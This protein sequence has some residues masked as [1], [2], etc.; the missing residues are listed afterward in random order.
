MLSLVPTSQD[1]YTAAALLKKAR[2]VAMPTETVYGL[3]ADAFEPTAIVKIFDAKERPRFDPLIVH[4]PVGPPEDVLRTLVVLDDYAPRGKEAVT[5]LTRV[6]WPGPLT[7]VLPRSNAVPDLV[8]SGKPTVAVRMP[9][10][11]TTQALL[12]A[13]GGPLVAPSANRFGSISPTTA[14]AVRAELDGRIDAVVDAGPTPLGVESTVLAVDPDGT[15]RLLRPGALPVEDIEAVAGPVVRQA[16]LSV[17]ERPEAPGQ[18]S[19]HYA[20][21]TPLTLVDDLT[22]PLVGAPP[23]VGL[24]RVLG[25]VEEAQAAYEAQGHT[26]VIARSLSASTLTEAAQ[27]LFAVL[28]ELDESTAEALIAERCPSHVGLGHAIADRLERAAR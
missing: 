18:L 26:V 21:G 27:R 11:P 6:F 23:C 14:D 2:L 9:A 17:G 3:A 22:K 12:K 5:T 20:P 16:P 8:T 7:L 13:F 1:L 4:L 19:R 25:P 15:L 24:L 10:H 28:R